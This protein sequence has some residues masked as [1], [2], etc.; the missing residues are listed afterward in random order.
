MGI[1]TYISKAKSGGTGRELL[2]L[3]YEATSGRQYHL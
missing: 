1:G 3:P 2:S